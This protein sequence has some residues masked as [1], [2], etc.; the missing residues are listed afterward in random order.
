MV[1]AL[2]IRNISVKGRKFGSAAA[3]EKVEK[4]TEKNAG[5]IRPY[6]FESYG[7]SFIPSFQGMKVSDTPLSCMTQFP[8][9]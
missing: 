4:N 1:S 8:K 3:E 6:S 5:T 7:R 2:F 9:I